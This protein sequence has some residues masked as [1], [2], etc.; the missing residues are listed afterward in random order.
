MKIKSQVNKEDIETIIPII[1]KV[2]KSNTKGTVIYSWIWIL[3]A[4][5]LFI[6]GLKSIILDS[7]KSG[8]I[9]FL[10]GLTIAVAIIALILDLF[11]ILLMINYPVFLKSLSIEDVEYEIEL[12]KQYLKTIRHVVVTSDYIFVH[13]TYKMKS[14]YFIFKEDN[15]GEFNYLKQLLIPKGNSKKTYKYIKEK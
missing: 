12:N 3:L 8:T 14:R 1:R 13:S 11:L 9:D 15:T 4:T 6:W 10:G 2:I 5:P 7:I